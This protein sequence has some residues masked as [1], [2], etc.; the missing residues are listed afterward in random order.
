MTSKKVKNA[1]GYGG[2]WVEYGDGYSA[3]VDQNMDDGLYYIS[4]HKGEMPAFNTEV[5]KTL[6]ELETKMRKVEPDLR[7]WQQP[8]YS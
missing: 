5:V 6:D 2:L 7:K 1:M 4:Y 3:S 8:D